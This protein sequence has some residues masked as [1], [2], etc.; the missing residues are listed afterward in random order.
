[1]GLSV[2]EHLTKNP[3]TLFLLDGVGGFL[4][5]FLIGVVLTR[6]QTHIGMPLA[7]LYRLAIIG[8]LCG[9]YSL[10]CVLFLKDN[11]AVF[12]K[13]IAIVNSVYCCLSAGVVIYYFTEM[14]MLGIVY[15]ALEILVILSVIALEL[16]AYSH[17][18]KKP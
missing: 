14:T 12:L 10:S 4:T 16:R 1:M 18:N 9:L 3:R 15:F 6:W 17:L 11:V 5:A 2:V 8:L 7:I 13:T